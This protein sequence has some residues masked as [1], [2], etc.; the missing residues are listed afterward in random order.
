MAFVF[1]NV[2]GEMLFLNKNHGFHGQKN[3]ENHEMPRLGSSRVLA[4]FQQILIVARKPT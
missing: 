1:S 3:I 2:S 4:N